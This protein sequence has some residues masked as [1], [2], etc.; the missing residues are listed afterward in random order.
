MTLFVN[1]FDFDSRSSCINLAVARLV[2]CVYG[3]WK[4]A[5]YPYTG[6]LSFPQEFREWKNGEILNFLYLQ[7]PQAIAI[8]QSVAVILLLLCAL[9]LARGFSAFGGALFMTHMEGLAFAIENEKTATNLAFF[10]IFYGIFRA[11]DTITL[12]SYLASRRMSSELLA[13][14]LRE[15]PDSKPVRIESLKWFL[16]CLAVIYFFTGFSKLQAGDW[17]LAWG[18]WENIR[19]AILNNCMVR[20]LAVSPLGE[21]LIGQPVLL[22]IAGYGTLLL[23]LGFLPA[24][25]A[26]VSITPF[27]VCLAGMHAVI[28]MAMDV[29]YFTDMAFLYAAFFAWDSLAGRLQHGRSLLVVYDDQCS[30]CMRVLLLVKRLHIA[31]ELRFVGRTDPDALPGYDYENAMF[32]FDKDGNVFRG[33]DG[34]VQIASFIGLTKPL[35]W[36]MAFPP[37]A[38]VGRWIYSWVARNRS[39][40]SS[41]RMGN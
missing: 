29:D 14:N 17:T 7:S 36:F 3:I 23:E 28:L 13:A 25:L 41:C 40:I 22:S 35:A 2:L 4:I 24:V 39:C 8:E 16:V 10:L 30:F 20:T 38:V 31:G 9:G 15:K 34:F 26:G 6:A 18:S 5:S 37:F 11:T 19:L 1:Y 12:D 27:L 32:V 21:F 33:Y